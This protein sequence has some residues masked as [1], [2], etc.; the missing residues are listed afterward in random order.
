MP[1]EGEGIGVI[2]D[3]G[4]GFFSAFTLSHYFALDLAESERKC[5]EE[6]FELLTERQLGQ[7]GTLVYDFGRGKTLCYFEEAPPGLTCGGT[8]S[9][10]IEGTPYESL[11]HYYRVKHPGLEVSEDARA[12]KVSFPGLGR[13]TPVAAHML[14]PRVMNDNVPGKLSNVDKISAHDRRGFLLKFWESLG[15]RPLG[16][17]IPGL[18]PGFW[19]PTSEKVSRFLPPL[20]R[21]GSSQAV[22]EPSASGI[23]EFKAYYRNRKRLLD[24]GH[25]YRFPPTATRVVRLAHPYQHAEAASQLAEDLALTLGRWTKKQFESSLVPYDD[26]GE[27][28]A[29]LKD[30]EEGLV[31]FVL[32]SEPA[33]YYEA[34]FNLPGWRVKRVKESTLKGQFRQLCHGARD[35][36]T[37]KS[38]NELGKRRWDGFVDMNA[39]DLLQLLD[40]VPFRTENLGS[41]ES[42]LVIDVGFDRRFF[43]VS[44]LVCRSS[45]KSPDFRIYTEVHHK[46]DHKNETVNS[47][48]LQNAILDLFG[49][50]MRRTFD[51]LES[52]L[53][54]RDGRVVG[55]EIDGIDK[56]VDGLRQR[57]FLEM[58]SPVDVV[59]YHKDSL[60]NLRF[61][62]V[63]GNTISNP[64]EGTGIS[65]DRDTFVLCSTGE[66]TL[67]QGTAEPAVL[68]RVKGQASLGGGGVFV[69]C[70]CPAQLVQPNRG[71]AP[72][73]APEKD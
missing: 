20:V 21:F 39:L 52:L 70:G 69:F 13:P 15:D 10:V 46:A 71:S 47:V 14:R 57:G 19:Q 54:L 56:A 34:S 60:K 33:A 28:Y 48:L 22:S 53:V 2:A 3:V 68:V 58:D 49:A 59:E 23:S 62:E 43:A 9:F 35:R 1:I 12:V 37:G 42:Q 25:C 11:Y 67:T 65:L 55:K 40:A 8:G 6:R 44:L 26:A 16:P 27:A 73:I 5:R 51:P 64:L 30:F 63:Q 45:S 50:A 4:T 61:W 18:L 29:R 41:F 66:S 72:A 36:R 24:G 17:N 32:D 31:L 7:K 38:V